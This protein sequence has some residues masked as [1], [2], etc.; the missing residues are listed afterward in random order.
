MIK[1]L[2][3]DPQHRTSFLL[4]PSTATFSQF[5]SVAVDDVVSAVRALPDKTY[6]L[7]PLSTTN[8]KAVVSV[9]APSHQPFQQVTVERLY[10]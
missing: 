7:Y 1:L 9:I 10:S 6:A 2:A 4:N 5:Q 3:Y 8:L